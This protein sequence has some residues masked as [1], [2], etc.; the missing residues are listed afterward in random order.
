M[1]MILDI[2]K[3]KIHALKTMPL[4]EIVKHIWFY[5]LWRPQG[6]FLS[7]LFCDSSSKPLGVRQEIWASKWLKNC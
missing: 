3:R 7:I 4:S 1:C 6:A 2:G 5:L